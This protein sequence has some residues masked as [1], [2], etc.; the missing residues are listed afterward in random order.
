MEELGIPFAAARLR[1]QLAG[2][3]AELGQREEALEALQACH[4]I[5]AH[6][7]AAP[8]LSATRS[9][10]EELK[11]RP[12]SNAPRATEGNGLFSPREW[13]VAQGVARRRSNKQIAAA[14]SI[15]QRTVER[16][17]HNI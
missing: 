2:R 12:P 3:L 15:G 6:L 8:E 9:V 1:R 16:H 17:C 13:Q 5:F 11:K 14:L 4:E 10:Y 7:G